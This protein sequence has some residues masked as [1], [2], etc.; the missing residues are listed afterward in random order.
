MGFQPSNGRLRGWAISTTSVTKYILV[1]HPLREQTPPDSMLS[2]SNKW[3][4]QRRQGKKV[5]C[6]L[7][8]KWEYEIHYCVIIRLWDS[9]IISKTI[10]QPLYSNK[11]ARPNG[12]MD[13]EMDTGCSPIQNRLLNRSY[14]FSAVRCHHFL[15]WKLH[16]RYIMDV[17]VF[18]VF[19]ALMDV[20]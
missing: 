16:G 11:P 14:R 6:C 18:L 15:L 12:I 8:S 1:I 7:V 5:P 13:L 4:N 20:L 9:C 3:I 2:K 19:S 10:L 17:L